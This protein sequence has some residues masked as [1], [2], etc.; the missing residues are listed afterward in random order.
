MLGLLRI[1]EPPDQDSWTRI[2][3]VGEA[4]GDSKLAL[5]SER[6]ESSSWGG[7]VPHGKSKLK[8]VRSPMAHI[9]PRAKKHSVA[10]IRKEISASL[11]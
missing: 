10:R 1:E 9:R 7:M 6:S 2:W 3:S 8:S 5:A 4:Y 11:V